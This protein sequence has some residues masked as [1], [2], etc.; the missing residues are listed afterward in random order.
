MANHMTR[1]LFTVTPE[2][3]AA[4]MRKHGFVPQT[5]KAEAHRRALAERPPVP[6]SE[7]TDDLKRE[8]MEALQR[9]LDARGAAS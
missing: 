3:A 6:Y 9:R 4:A 8:R 7:T 5:D 2:R 1:D